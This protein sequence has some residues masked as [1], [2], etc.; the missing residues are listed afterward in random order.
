MLLNN[1][2]FEDNLLNM[3]FAAKKQWNSWR[4]RGVVSEGLHTA[5]AKEVMENK[6]EVDGSIHNSAEFR[7]SP[8]Q[9]LVQ[10]T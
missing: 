9:A 2:F 8:A 5:L 6:H 3:G 1:N 4:T 7:S 10:S